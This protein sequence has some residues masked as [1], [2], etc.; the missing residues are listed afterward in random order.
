MRHGRGILDPEDREY[1]GGAREGAGAEDGL[2]VEEACAD[3]V[4]V[5]GG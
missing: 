2:E 4:E 1:R 5:L 3:A